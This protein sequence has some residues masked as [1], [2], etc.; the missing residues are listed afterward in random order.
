MPIPARMNENSPIC[1]RLADTVSAVL[2]GYRNAS[3]IA[4]AA[5]DLPNRMI[6]T[7]MRTF[8]GCSSR[9]A[10][11]KSMPTDTKKSTENASRSGSD[12]SA[13]R[14]LSADSRITIPAKK[15]PSANETPNSL[16]E[17]NAM[18]IAVA[19]TQSVKS[20]REPVRATCQSSHGKTRRPTRS[21]SP[22][23]SPTLPSVSPSVRRSP[24]PA[25]DGVATDGRIT[26]AST[27]AR[28]STM[29]QPTAMRPLMDSSAPRL[30]SARS[31]TTVLATDSESPNTIPPPILHPQ[32]IAT[33]MPIAVATAIC[34]TAPGTAILRTDSRSSSERWSPTPNISSITPISASSRVSSGSAMK[35]GVAGPSSAPAAR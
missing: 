25:T 14:W 13:A 18:P 32:S 9:I 31:S 4:N 29:S 2:S 24:S 19:M 10:G 12:S 16:A 8:S 6:E 3:T 35:P 20:S 1:A 34:T 11:L 5:S 28:S 21:I 15:A 22:M 7:T 23:N 27:I 26:S 33:P 30:S 17:P